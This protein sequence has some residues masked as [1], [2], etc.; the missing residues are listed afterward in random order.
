[1][2][3]PGPSDT[4]QVVSCDPGITVVSTRPKEAE[5]PNGGGWDG[6]AVQSR[7]FWV[8]PKDT[9]EEVLDGQAKLVPSPRADLR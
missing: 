9:W 8:S 5:L 2:E 3:S 4:E 1:M 7:V 6:E